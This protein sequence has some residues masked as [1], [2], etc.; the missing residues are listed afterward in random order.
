MI[1]VADRNVAVIDEFAR[2]AYPEQL[3][4]IHSQTFCDDC[5]TGCHGSCGNYY[6]DINRHKENAARDSSVCHE[7][8]DDD[9]DWS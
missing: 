5:C 2:Q 9:W 7:F 8:N 1:Y 3:F 6:R 4:R